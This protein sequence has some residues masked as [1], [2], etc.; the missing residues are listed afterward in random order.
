LISLLLLFYLHGLYSI[1]I[2]AIPTAPPAPAAAG[3]EMRRRIQSNSCGDVFVALSEPL[4][5]KLTVTRQ[6][7]A[8]RYPDVFE[9]GNPCYGSALDSWLDRMLVG[10]SETTVTSVDS[11]W[12][13]MMRCCIPSLSILENQH[14]ASSVAQK[15]PDASFEINNAL[16]I[17]YE[18]KYSD[19]DLE[20][21]RTELVDKF[22][23]WAVNCFPQ[24]CH[25]II[26][27]TSA[28]G[29]INILR[30]HYGYDTSF[31][32]RLLKSYI[33]ANESDRVLFAVDIL[34][35]MRWIVSVNGPNKSFHLTPGRR[36][37]TNN[38]HHITW[39]AAGLLK[40]HNSSV[41]LVTMG[42]I[43]TVYTHQPPLRHIEF[44]E[45]LQ[46]DRNN[47]TRHCLISRI[48]VR[49][50]SALLNGIVTRD[51]IWHQIQAAVFELHAIGFAHCD[52]SINNAY[53]DADGIVFL[54]DLEY[55]TPINSPP[56]HKIR[57]PKTT[58]IDS[59]ATASALDMAQLETFH[60]DL[61]G[62]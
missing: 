27:I 7:Y 22:H 9:C 43:N 25:S 3:D 45:V 24:G 15:R 8:A 17:K 41:S 36:I 31:T 28:L 14:D 46:D 48:G 59:I 29:V 38:K 19:L 53:V 55:L 4:P 5:F 37:K 21:A 1:F 33:V 42:Y 13:S 39:T 61:C 34:K 23:K 60:T 57:V 11:Y 30:I 50:S 35:I 18:A 40:E 62:I 54:D 6:I 26:G 16:V 51:S 20:N 56:P 12:K 44:G 58:V 10:S 2:I 47:L 49:L 52:I 32:T